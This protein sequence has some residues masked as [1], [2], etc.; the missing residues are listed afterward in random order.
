MFFVT[1]HYFFFKSLDVDWGLN[2]RVSQHSTESTANTAD[3]LGLSLYFLRCKGSWNKFMIFFQSSKMIHISKFHSSLWNK[4]RL[5]LTRIPYQYP[6]TNNGPA[7]KCSG[8]A[9]WCWPE[10]TRTADRSALDFVCVNWQGSSAPCLEAN[11]YSPPYRHSTAGI[12][13]THKLDFDCDVPGRR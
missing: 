6:G 10:S 7:T 1:R 8:H 13:S 2:R 5:W 4:F 12:L 11:V 3:T 9:Q